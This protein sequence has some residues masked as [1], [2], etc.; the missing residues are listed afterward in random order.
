MQ[1]P[2]LFKSQTEARPKLKLNKAF[3]AEC[4]PASF[5]NYRSFVD[6][7]RFEKRSLHSPSKSDCCVACRQTGDCFAFE[8][9]PVKALCNYYVG[10]EDANNN[11]DDT[12]NKMCP[13]GVGKGHMELPGYPLWPS[14]Y[15]HEYGPCLNGIADGKGL[16][17]QMVGDELDQQ[18]LGLPREEDLEEEEDDEEIY[19]LR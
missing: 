9:D 14:H 6:K 10:M 17:S 19:D 7:R 15:G 5:K 11:N 16:D 13:S 4:Q 2:A 18:L 3:V 12:K 8:Y 1:M